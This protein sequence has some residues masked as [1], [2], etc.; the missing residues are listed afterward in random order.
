VTFQPTPELATSH[1]RIS[2]HFIETT[3]LPLRLFEWPSRICYELRLTYIF[4][5]IA[6]NMDK[7]S[8]TERASL[9]SSSRQEL[10]PSRLEDVT[11]P[12]HIP[13]T[14]LDDLRALVTCRV[15]I[16][17][18][19]EPY[20]ISCGHTFCYTCLRQWF[21]RDRAQKTCPDCRS[22]VVQQ[23]APAY[24]VCWHGVVNL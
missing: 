21:D 14:E 15:C 5:P 12:L 22:K 23:P 1:S 10:C 2:S 18:L 4:G 11:V 17:P 3:S 9:H 13:G 24:L 16:R 19:Y 6:N 20:T 8:T 7:P